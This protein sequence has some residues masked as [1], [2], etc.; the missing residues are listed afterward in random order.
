[1]TG[2]V[3]DVRLNNGT[4]SRRSAS[5]SSGCLTTRPSG[6]CS[7]RSSAATAASTRP[8]STA[9]RPASAAP[10]RH[11]GCPARSCSSP[12]SSGT[13]TRVTTARSAAFEASL[14]RL[15]LDYVDLYLDPLAEAEPGSLRRDVAGASS[16]P[17]RRAGPRDRRV[18]LPDRSPAAAAR[19]DRGRPG[20]EPDRAAPAAPA[21]VAAPLPRRTRHRDRG[22]EPARS[23]RSA[24]APGR[25]GAGPR[26]AAR[27]PR[28]CCAGTCSWAT[29]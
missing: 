6:R 25:R 3:P 4:T 1:M 20:G 12:P 21:G 23:G 15:R 9:T 14:A 22:L 26:H 29:W 2:V 13:T 5:A 10:S 16:A 11:A 7:P 17:R 24:A 28:S 19:R 8:R 18:E 27:R